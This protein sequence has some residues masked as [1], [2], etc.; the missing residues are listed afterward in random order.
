[1]KTLA[2]AADIAEVL[3]RLT[4]VRR[5]SPR[6]WGRMSAHQMICHLRDAFLIATDPSQVR[7]VSGPL[8]RTV[9]KWVALYAP[10]RWP[11][12]VPTRP[13]IDQVKGGGVGPSDFAADVASLRAAVVSIT[14]SPADFFRGRRHPIFGELTQ[15]A[16]LR[17]GYLH[18]DHH[19][20]QFG[21]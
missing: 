21:V 20:R 17:W 8:N 1:V 16:W 5:D 2:N 14:A 15:S 11:A 18:I 7:Q 3:E 13:E 10:L 6:R 19:L 12:G 9:V 4:H